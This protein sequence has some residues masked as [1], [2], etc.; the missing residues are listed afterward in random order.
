MQTIIVA[1]SEGVIGPKIVDHL[2][3]NK[4]KVICLDVKLGHD[5]TDRLFV[6]R[7]FK[8]N[9]ADVLINLFALNHHVKDQKYENSFFEMDPE[10]VNEYCNVN[11]TTLYHVCRE[12]MK[13]RPAEK[14]ISIINFG[15]LYALRSPRPEIYPQGVMKHIGYVTS[16]HAVI[17][18]TKYI[19]NH[20][21]PE[22]NINCI[23]PGGI[24]TEEMSA[25]F[26]EKFTKNVPYGRM[27]KV[28]DL[29]GIIELLC[30]EKSNYMT[31]C[32]IP[33]DGGWT[34]Q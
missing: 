9:S 27:S 21:A 11:V 1:G 30:S 28:E 32:V 19:A 14:R 6:E 34:V 24:E 31:G 15:S 13:N 8:E 18:L 23:C 4:N 26:K 22:V 29:F 7:F 3:K 12:F 17:G 33:V 20:F 25:T 16:K 5:L 10:E 2:K